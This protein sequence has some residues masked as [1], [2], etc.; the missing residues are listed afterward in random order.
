MSPDEVVAKYVEDGESGDRNQCT[1]RDTVPAPGHP[2]VEDDRGHEVRGCEREVLGARHRRQ[3]REGDEDDLP[4]RGRLVEAADRGR[5]RTDGER[6]GDCVGR[7]VRGQHQ[8]R[9]DEPVHGDAE[10][11]RLREMQRAREVVERDRGQRRG[12][13]VLDLNEVVRGG[14]RKEPPDRRGENRLE[15]PREVHRPPADL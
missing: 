10:R 15:D 3:E 2:A 7:G 12:D 6:V 11:V 9:H 5:D 1:Q 8:L 14:E 4:A 13:G